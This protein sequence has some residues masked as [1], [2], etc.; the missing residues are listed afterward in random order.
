LFPL[1]NHLGKIAQNAPLM[2]RLLL[3]IVI[4]RAFLIGIRWGDNVEIYQNLMT[5]HRSF[6][7]YENLLQIAPRLIA[8]FDVW[9]DS[10][11]V[12]GNREG[13]ARRLLLSSA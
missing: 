7:Q 2:T 11:S 10:P 4:A 8:G 13:G 9:C 6:K 3:R 12:C 1:E 5:L